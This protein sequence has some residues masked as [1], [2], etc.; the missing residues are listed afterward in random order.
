[1]I[2]HKPIPGMSDRVYEFSKFIPTLDQIESRPSPRVI[3]SHLPLYLL[4]PKL[5]DTSKV[6]NK[7]NA[8]IIIF[9]H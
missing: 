1:M 2:S 9:R 3:K 6:N 5:L 4:H 7:M 8:V